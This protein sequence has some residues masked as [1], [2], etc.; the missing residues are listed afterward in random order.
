MPK[1]FHKNLILTQDSCAS[2]VLQLVLIG[3]VL[4]TINWFSLKMQLYSFTKNLLFENDTKTDRFFRSLKDGLPKRISCFSTKQIWNQ[5]YWFNSLGF[6]SIVVSTVTKT[7]IVRITV[8]INRWVT[9]VVRAGIG[10][11]ISRPLA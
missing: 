6:L 7:T 1:F 2:Q 11:S 10:L 4:P 8:S 9:I 5:K 3:K